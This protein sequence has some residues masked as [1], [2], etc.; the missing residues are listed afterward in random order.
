MSSNYHHFKVQAILDGGCL[1]RRIEPDPASSQGSHGSGDELAATSGE[2]DEAHMLLEIISQSITMLFKIANIVREAGP[3]DRFTEALQK[4]ETVPA[5][6]D[7]KY[8][9]YSHPKLP[10]NG[11]EHVAVRLGRAMAKRRQFID[12]CRGQDRGKEVSDQLYL[13]S[14]RSQSRKSLKQQHG[15]GGGSAEAPIESNPPPAMQIHADDMDRDNSSLRTTLS[16][17]TSTF[18][19]LNMSNLSEL[20]KASAQ[21]LPVKCPVCLTSQSFREEEAWR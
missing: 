6:S 14:G 9:M 7:I 15:S 3:R 21:N 8:V 17:A 5:A 18:A 4:S 20:A 10:D 11:L 16:T 2:D 1:N 19:V 12:Y 13:Q